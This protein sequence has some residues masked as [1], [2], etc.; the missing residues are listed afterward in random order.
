MNKNTRKITRIRVTRVI[1]IEHPSSWS[2]ETL[3]NKAKD[4][5]RYMD[6]DGICGKIEW[7]IVSNSIEKEH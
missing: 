5:S 6:T 4:L 3:K 7:D 1:D 2:F